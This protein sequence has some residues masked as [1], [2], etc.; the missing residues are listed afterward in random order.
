MTFG[1]DTGLGPAAD[2]TDVVDELARRVSP[3]ASADTVFGDPVS[4][5]DV[6]VIPVAKVS[7]AIGGGGGAGSDDAPDGEDF[8]QGTGGAAAVS[9]RPLGYIEMN[10]WGTQFHALPSRANAWLPIA[11]AGFA[12]WLCLRAIGALR[13]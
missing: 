5:G 13:R 4:K 3:N 6:T 2:A 10:E 1:Y 12:F 9:A 8:G 11:A 7:W